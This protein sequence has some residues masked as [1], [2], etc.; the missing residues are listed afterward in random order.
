[1][2]I[3]NSQGVK[4]WLDYSNWAIA[5]KGTTREGKEIVFYAPPSK[6]HGK[7]TQNIKLGLQNE[8]QTCRRKLIK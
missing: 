5:G 2:S 4:P 8:R 1:M 7:M 6:E 3:S